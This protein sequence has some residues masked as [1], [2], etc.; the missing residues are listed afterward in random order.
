MRAG[1]ACPAPLLGA[2]MRRQR[3]GSNNER[4]SLL[5]A[6]ALFDELPAQRLACG[7]VGTVVEQLDADT[8]QVE[9]SDD[10]GRGGAKVAFSQSG[11]AIPRP[12]GPGPEGNVQVDRTQVHS[13]EDLR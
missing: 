2:V 4:P 1:G 9:F 11:V 6:V 12:Y 5:D 7:Q 10:Q 3:D 8:L 13:P